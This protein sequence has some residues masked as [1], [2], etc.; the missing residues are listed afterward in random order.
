[1]SKYFQIVLTQQ[2]YQRA[3]KPPV[4]LSEFKSKYLSSMGQKQ[5]KHPEQAVSNCK[6]K[7]DFSGHVAFWNKKGTSQLSKVSPKTAL[8][9]LSPDGL[10]GREL[11]IHIFSAMTQAVVLG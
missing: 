10:H 4:V 3:I 6:S 1:M 5:R 2:F 7:R 8:Q 11:N 9:G